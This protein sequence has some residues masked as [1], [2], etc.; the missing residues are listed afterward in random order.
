MLQ[1]CLENIIVRT[2]LAAVCGS[3]LCYQCVAV[4]LLF[5]G[6]GSVNVPA[7]LYILLPHYIAA[8]LYT[9]THIATVQIGALCS[10]CGSVYHTA[11]IE[12]HWCAVNE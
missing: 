12:E 4:S 3:L 11:T 7:T 8:T 2:C 9:A 6:L 5:A 1:R 10:D